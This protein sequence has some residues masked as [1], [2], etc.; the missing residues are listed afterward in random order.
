M[1]RSSSPRTIRYSSTTSANDPAGVTCSA[2]EPRPP[3]DIAINSPTSLVPRSDPLAPA[4][5]GPHPRQV[6]QRPTNRVA[7][8][9][10]DLPLAAAV[11]GIGDMVSPLGL[12]PLLTFVEAFCDGKVG[13]EVFWAGPVPVPLP[14]RG[15]D[16][17]T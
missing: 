15:V 14:W 16:G 1:L 2:A 3:Y 12:R 10:L 17:V 13:H 9:M 11:L 4:L 7:A 8:R 5:A 6:K